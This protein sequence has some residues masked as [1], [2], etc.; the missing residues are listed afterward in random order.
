MKIKNQSGFTLVEGLLVIIA[1]TLVAFVGY[2]VYNSQK[3]ANQTL[4]KASSASQKSMPKAPDYFVL[5]D[6]GIKIKKTSDIKDFSFRSDPTV[7]QS[8]YVHSDRFDAALKKCYG[9]FQDSDAAGNSFYAIGRVDGKYTEGMM[10]EAGFYITP[11]IKQFDNFFINGE[12]PNGF[13]ACKNEAFQEEFS[14][15]RHNLAEQLFKAVE[16]S[17]KI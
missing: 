3:D 15:I 9:E 4:D 10:D 11:A 14:N 8:R 12:P 6:M 13:S 17:E 5:E 2:Y 16:S 7:K 1:L